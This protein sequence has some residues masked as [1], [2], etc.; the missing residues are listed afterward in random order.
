MAYEPAIARRHFGPQE[1]RPLAARWP[2]VMA[3]L[4]GASRRHCRSEDALIYAA[5]D[6]AGVLGVADVLA[7]CIP[8]WTTAWRERV[9]IKHMP[10]RP[11][12]PHVVLQGVGEYRGATD[13]EVLLRWAR[14]PL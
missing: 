6:L 4:A 10:R 11:D 5:G 7:A 12:L 1:R 14:G 3:D 13:P 9:R 8:R 2:A